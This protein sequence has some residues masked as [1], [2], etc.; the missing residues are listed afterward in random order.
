MKLLIFLAITAQLVFSGSSIAAGNVNNFSKLAIQINP[1]ELKV[2]TGAGFVRLENKPKSTTKIELSR[3]FC[4]ATDD[5]ASVPYPYS[6][7]SNPSPLPKIKISECKTNDNSQLFDYKDGRIIGQTGQC[8]T[9]YAPNMKEFGNVYEITGDARYCDT[10]TYG[11]MQGEMSQNNYYTSLR[12]KACN[13]S[14]E[15]QWQIDLSANNRYQIKA[16]DSNDSC[17]SLSGLAQKGEHVQFFSGP[18]VC[19]DLSPKTWVISPAKVNIYSSRF[20][21]DTESCSA[22]ATQFTI[23]TP[24]VVIEKFVPIIL[25]D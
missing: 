9:R 22:G 23:N 20:T 6:F 18:L 4:L 16:T 2:S 1:S 7:P 19:R 12:F 8:L 13:G 24:V 3:P 10:L 15:Q 25:F 21:I 17:V 5:R 11:K 14:M